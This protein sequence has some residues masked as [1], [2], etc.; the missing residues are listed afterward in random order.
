MNID[1]RMLIDAIIGGV[2]IPMG[3][4][5]KELTPFTGNTWNE[6]WDWDKSKL[7]QLT[8][9]TL[10]K[11]YFQLRNTTYET[12]YDTVMKIFNTIIM[13]SDKDLYT[14]ITTLYYVDTFRDGGIRLFESNTNI[15]YYVN[16]KLDSLS[17]GKIFKHEYPGKDGSI[18][19]YGDEE[20]YI[21]NL[22][23]SKMGIL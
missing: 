3:G 18:L 4:F 16:H 23:N 21:K 15:K 2:N 13:A 20:R 17:R 1:K 5:S 7:Q 6:H 14:N 10:E 9:N 19:I 12:N 22:L 8:Y 11:I